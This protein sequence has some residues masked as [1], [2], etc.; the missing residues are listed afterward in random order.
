MKQSNSILAASTGIA[1]ESLRRIALVKAHGYEAAELQRYTDTL[2][3]K[4]RTDTRIVTASSVRLR[5][6]MMAIE[7]GRSSGPN[8][9]GD[10]LWFWV[11]YSLS[12]AFFGSAVLH[13]L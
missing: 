11:L 2:S 8:T 6:A 7:G 4:V 9:L 12:D 13:A 5:F 3:G 10:Q 1:Q